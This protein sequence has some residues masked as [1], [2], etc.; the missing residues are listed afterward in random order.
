MPRAA[1]TKPLEE[2][3]SIPRRKQVTHTHTTPLC[4]CAAVAHATD[5]YT[6]VKFHTPAAAL[7]P[8]PPGASLLVDALGQWPRAVTLDLYPGKEGPEPGVLP[9]PMSAFQVSVGSLYTCSFWWSS[10]IEQSLYLT[11]ARVLFM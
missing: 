5:L 4:A 11:A 1:L 7:P 3:S 9:R 8:L 6:N 2:C 10:D